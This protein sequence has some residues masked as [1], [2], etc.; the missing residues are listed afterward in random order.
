M[1]GVEMTFLTGVL[2]ITGELV[3]IGRVRFYLI[4]S[5]NFSLILF[6]PG[7]LLHMLSVV[8]VAP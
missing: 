5:L 3:R 7:F 1:E 4:P 6:L 2:R 8:P